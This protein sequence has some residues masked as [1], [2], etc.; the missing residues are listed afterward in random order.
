MK[1]YVCKM[2]GRAMKADKQPPYCYAD[3]MDSIEEIGSEDAVKMGLF[4]TTGGVK[5]TCA[6]DKEH[7]VAE[8]VND[9]RFCP[10]T[11]VPLAES[12]LGTFEGGSLTDFQNAVMQ[13]V[14]R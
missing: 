2:C 9:V 8:F 4:S 6:D 3:H 7:F 1:I 5:I 10:F 12:G 11:G 14:L 13:F